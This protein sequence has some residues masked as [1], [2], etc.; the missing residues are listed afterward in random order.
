MVCPKCNH[1]VDDVNS[2]C[3]FC[4]EPLKETEGGDFYGSFEMKDNILELIYI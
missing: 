4:N 2:V 1:E 3:P